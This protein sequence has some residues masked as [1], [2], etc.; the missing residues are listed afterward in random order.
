MVEILILIYSDSKDPSLSCNKEDWFR[1]KYFQKCFYSYVKSVE[2]LSGRDYKGR[3]SVPVRHGP[4]LLAGPG[5]P[6]APGGGPC[7]GLEPP[8]HRPDDRLIEG[9]GH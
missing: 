6:V 3:S 4:P 1:M 2:L 8:G 5:A 7:G 9:P